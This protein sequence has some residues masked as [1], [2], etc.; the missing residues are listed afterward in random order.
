MIFVMPLDPSLIDRLLASPLGEE[1]Y[2]VCEKM[3]DAGYE[4][5]WVG[6]CIRDML[7]GHLPEEID[8][9]TDALPDEVQKLFPKNDSKGKD[10][11]SIVVSQKGQRFEITTFREDHENSDGRRPE[12]VKFGTREKDAE[13]RDLTINAIYWNPISRDFFD[14][15]EGQKDLEQKLI[16]FIGEP[17]VRITEDALR[18]LR[19]VRIR[20]KIKGQYHP[21]TFAALHK[22]ASHS[23]VLSGTRMIEEIEKIL[24]GPN[25]DVA[26]E[27][28]WETD[29][30]EHLI[31]E[32][33]KCKGVAQPAEYHLEGDVWQHTL[34]C[35]RSYSEDHGIDTRMAA[36]FHDI[37]KA[38][39]FSLQ[40]RI[41]FD[42]HAEAS[43]EITK[44]ILS[45]FQ[46]PTKR[47]EKI[48]WI[49]DHHMMM[50][51]FAEMET[52][53]K[54]HWYYH[55]WFIELLQVFWLDIAGTIPSDFSLYEKIVN[56][57]NHFL[58][59]HPR[60]EKPLLSGEE[61]MEQLSLQPGE[62][63]GKVLHQLHDAQIR[64]EVTT[65]KEAL[66]FL[67]KNF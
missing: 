19:A 30:L 26:F 56:D 37:G 44:T 61:I 53:R 60:P 8:V 15:Y 4:T 49:I 11:G 3:A 62:Q 65:K 13:R 33:Y 51:S 58:D 31:P 45:R 57:Y 50:G 52:E 2:K 59:E 22:L 12:S 29:I 47:V 39:T 21:E 63:V 55:P 35:L 14:P 28:L 42:K 23:K 46:L 67:K 10:F 25:P 16:R 38:E 9:A 66:E 48:C 6:G 36:L 32:L 43:A 1:A 20:S 7:Q 27:D 17:E 64:K 24:M 41:R 5:W 34:Q 18:L 54:A 40:E